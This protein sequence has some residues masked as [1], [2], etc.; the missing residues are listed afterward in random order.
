[1]PSVFELVLVLSDLLVCGLFQ[2]YKRS[3]SVKNLTG[4]K[5]KKITSKPNSS[6]RVKLDLGK[7]DL[8][9][10]NL[11][12]NQKFISII[13]Y[14]FLSFSIEQLHNMSDEGAVFVFTYILYL[15]N[16]F[17]DFYFSFPCNTSH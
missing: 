17:L 8:C 9:D 2:L 6:K 4:N 16:D 12:F 13:F 5:N 15:S 3:I 7:F 10:K 14:Y 11:C 1:M